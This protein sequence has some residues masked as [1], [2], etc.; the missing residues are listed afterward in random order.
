M[1]HS[2]GRQAGRQSVLGLWR[3]QP[4]KWLNV[5][6]LHGAL[7]LPEWVLSLQP[8]LLILL[9]LILMMLMLMCY[10]PADR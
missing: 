1:M 5:C 9:M 3:S 10:L 7:C 4:F 6:I 8:S 2:A